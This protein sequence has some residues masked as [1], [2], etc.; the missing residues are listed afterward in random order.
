MIYLG[1][2]YTYHRG[3]K[4]CDECNRS[5][6]TMATITYEDGIGYGGT[7]CKTHSLFPSQVDIGVETVAEVMALWNRAES[8]VRSAV[9]FDQYVGK[10][11]ATI[12]SGRV[13]GEVA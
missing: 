13:S 9:T 12:E 5:T 1:K 8:A 7:F 6:P 3:G 11:R 10:L 2:G 4:R